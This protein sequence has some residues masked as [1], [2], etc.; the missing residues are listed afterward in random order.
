MELGDKANS[1][2]FSRIGQIWSGKHEL[3]R[4]ASQALSPTFL[5]RFSV[6]RLGLKQFPELFHSTELLK[7]INLCAEMLTRTLKSAPI[8]SLVT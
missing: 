5:P 1:V 2:R 3:L 4:F 7:P 8:P 6:S